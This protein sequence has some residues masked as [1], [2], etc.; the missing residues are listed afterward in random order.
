MIGYLKIIRSRCRN[1]KSHNV[2]RYVDQKR[3]RPNCPLSHSDFRKKSQP[4]KFGSST[5]RYWYWYQEEDTSSTTTPM[6]G[7]STRYYVL[8]LLRTWFQVVL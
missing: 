8:L 1:A 5:R 4:S 6:V 3:S 2:L 7:S